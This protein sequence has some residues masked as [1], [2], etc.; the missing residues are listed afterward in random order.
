MTSQGSTDSPSSLFLTQA[1]NPLATLGVA[2]VPSGDVPIQ[3]TQELFVLV[4]ISER[5]L[6]A[7][8]LQTRQN[9][10]PPLHIPHQV[11]AQHAGGVDVH[12][13]AGIDQMSEAP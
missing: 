1:T 13:H 12:F 4:F 9:A 3:R 8:I 2:A 6:Q 10:E 7:A 5:Y 11:V